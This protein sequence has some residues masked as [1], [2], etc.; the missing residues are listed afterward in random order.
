MTQFDAQGGS[1]HQ[2]NSYLTTAD[3]AAIV[4]SLGDA[5]H[6]LELER[7][8]AP[9][10]GSLA[11]LDVAAH[12]RNNPYAPAGAELAPF[13]YADWYVCQM[14]Q[15]LHAIEQLLRGQFVPV[16]AWPTIR[17][18]AEL[19]GRVTWLL[20]PLIGL[21]S[22]HRRVARWHLE[23]ASSLLRAKVA[24]EAVGNP[25]G[26]SA[27]E[28]ELTAIV[29]QANDLFGSF[30]PDF[31]RIN[32]IDTWT[33]GGEKCIGLGAGI[34]LFEKRHL[35]DAAGI[36]D[37]LSSV[38]HPSFAAIAHQTIPN[39][40]ANGKFLTRPWA[41]NTNLIDQ[42]I[43]MACVIFSK[44]AYLVMNYKGFAGAPLIRWEKDI[45]PDWWFT[46]NSVGVTR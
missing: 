40:A 22:S 9:K 1:Q 27:A 38:S 31:R 8:A 19:A 36:Y 24:Q 45:A 42:Q 6:A 35:S 32:R 37:F 11:A 21:G 20:D 14:A 4:K 2:A 44:T 23:L 15:Y 34:E 3:Y 12:R 28:A 46:R 25:T 10:A 18:L 33:L 5:W 29:A 26:A 30:S 43:Q 7:R 16:M 17:A 13:Q 39:A 41:V